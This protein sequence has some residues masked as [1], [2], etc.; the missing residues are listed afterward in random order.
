VRGLYTAIYRVASRAAHAQLETID[1]CI[2]MSRYPA[3]PAVVHVERNHSMDWTA[4]STPIFAMVLLVCHYRLG[5]PNPEVVRAIND[6]LTRGP[7]REP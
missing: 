7:G 5:W 2:D 1:D 6:R 3:K 4:I